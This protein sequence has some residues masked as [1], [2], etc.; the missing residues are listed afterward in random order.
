MLAKISS[1]PASG[2]VATMPSR[3]MHWDVAVEHLAQPVATPRLIIEIMQQ[4]ANQ[5]EHLRDPIAIADIT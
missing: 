1:M 3:E 4:T 5:T 2:F